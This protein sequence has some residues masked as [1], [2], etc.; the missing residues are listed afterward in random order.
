MAKSYRQFC[1]VAKAAEI[2]AERWTLLVVREL[3][4]GS[5]H[6]NDLRRG[7][8]LMSPS[9]LSQRLRFLE[10]QG[11]VARRRPSAG[12]GSEYH[13]TRA[14]RELQPVIEGLGAWGKRWVRREATQSDDLDPGLLMW[15]IHRRLHVD[16]FPERR[17][18]MRFELTDVPAK[19][20]FYWLVIDGG[21]VDICLRDP[22]FDIA[23][24]IAV[25]LPTLTGI[26][27]GDIALDHAIRT[28][29]LTLHGA[30]SLRRQFQT[31]FKLSLFAGV[32]RES[33]VE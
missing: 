22:G 30:R 31:W 4:C 24:Y 17:T 18:V 27:L 9:L 29:A 21:K 8:P 1:P 25:D 23:L 32:T 14:G 33:V 2:L 3:L 11:V 15:D 6:F 13:L 5:Q 28:R 16:R 19:R 10:D 26:W 7:V 20:R 12:A